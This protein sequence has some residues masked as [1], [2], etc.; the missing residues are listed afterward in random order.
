MSLSPTFPL[1]TIHLR[2]LSQSPSPPNYGQLREYLL[3]YS[4]EDILHYLHSHKISLNV[5]ISVL[6]TET[7]PLLV[8]IQHRFLSIVMKLVEK[9]ADVNQECNDLLP[10]IL[11]I[12]RN[13]T[14]IADFLVNLPQ[15]DVNRTTK[16]GNSAIL[17][18]FETSNI[19][20]IHKLYRKGAKLPQ[21]S[22]LSLRFS[23]ESLEVFSYLSK[24]IIK[25]FLIREN[26][27]NRVLARLPFPLIRLLIAYI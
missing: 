6:G 20:F 23:K 18:A 24:D 13:R 2:P 8:T 15:I 9:G 11:A 7:T 16:S 1:E 12:Q 21:I 3:Y 26:L 14:K 5:T 25:L 22:E 4:S 27:R 19:Q 17:A 10:I